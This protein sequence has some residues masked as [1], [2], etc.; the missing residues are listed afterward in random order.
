MCFGQSEATSDTYVLGNL[1]PLQPPFWVHF[2]SYFRLYILLCIYTFLHKSEPT[3]DEIWTYFRYNLN[4]LQMGH[5]RYNLNLLQME[6]WTYFRLYILLCIYTFLHKSEPTSDTI[7]TY[8]RWN[9][10]LL[11]MRQ[12]LQIWS[13]FRYNLNLFQIVLQ[14]YSF[15]QHKWPI[16]EE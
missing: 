15:K 14:S 4:L 7:W 5:F 12:P 8:F 16:H 2:K 3:S 13:N 9:L 1:K 6:I 11:Q 10:N